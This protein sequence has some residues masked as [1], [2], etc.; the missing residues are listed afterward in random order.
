[1][2][3]TIYNPVPVLYSELPEAS[4]IQSGDQLFVIKNGKF[5]RFSAHL[6]SLENAYASLN[7]ATGSGTD[8]TT[9]EVSPMPVADIFQYIW[10]K[11]RQVGNV[12]SMKEPSFT[13]NT[14]FNK[15]FGTAS[16]TVTEG[17]DSRVTGA[18]Q[19]ATI[20]GNSVTKSDTQ[21]QLP[22]YPTLSTLNTSLSAETGTGTDITT[23][24]VASNTI[25]TILQSIWAKI[26]MVA[27]VT[28]TAVQ[29]ATIGGV[30]VTKSGTQLQFPANLEMTNGTWN[31]IGS[32][33]AISSAVGT[34]LKVGKL[35]F[36]FCR[37]NVS[38][39]TAGDPKFIAGIPEDL[40]PDIGAS[41]S[42]SST[43]TNGFA[44]ISPADGG[45]IVFTP[46][47][48]VTAVSVT[49]SGCYKVP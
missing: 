23:P 46:D 1:M 42:F 25:V 6:I 14:A 18:V 19:S 5:Y 20:G 35:V 34:Y 38:S 26:R 37:F 16:G 2:V 15:N 32:G 27:N 33:M 30:D 49:I 43:K 4:S 31:P 11:I 10:E 41:L 45:F 40:F 39:V 48:T 21:L 36:L 24:A 13:K 7:A 28:G 9:P 17:N 3:D 44:S 22:A 8:T 29:S 47:D 12:V